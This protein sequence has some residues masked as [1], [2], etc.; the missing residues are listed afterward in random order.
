MKYFLSL[1][2]IFPYINVVGQI[3]T[4]QIN[5][6]VPCCSAFPASFPFI[7]SFDIDNDNNYEFEI[8][9]VALG[10]EYGF[11]AKGIDNTQLN[12]AIP[13]ESNYPENSWN[14]YALG[15]PHTVLFQW[16]KWWLPNTGIKYLGFRRINSI[17]DTTYGWIKLDFKGEHVGY[18][19]SVFILDLAYSVIPNIH[20]FAGETNTTSTNISDAGQSVEIFPNPFATILNIGNQSNEIIKIYIYDSYGKLVLNQIVDELNRN[21]LN[22]SDLSNG[23]YFVVLDSNSTRK[24][25]KVIK[26]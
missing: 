17:A 14:D 2:I 23:L 25:V 8:Q 10:D 6:F 12:E 11:S 16:G 7:D 1:I 24:L 20:L 4:L 21:T 18:N 9:G 19:D 26:Q 5:S 22:L 3:H 15:M 13:F